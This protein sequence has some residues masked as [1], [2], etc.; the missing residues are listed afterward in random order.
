MHDAK[1]ALRK[2]EEL[3]D[4]GTTAGV[5]ALIDEAI[6]KMNSAPN[7][8]RVNWARAHFLQATTLLRNRQNPTPVSPAEKH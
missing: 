4:K 5:E 1:K 2:A 8:P 7:D 3:L 6:S